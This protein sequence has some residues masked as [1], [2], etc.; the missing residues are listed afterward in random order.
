[1][2]DSRQGREQAE[3]PSDKKFRASRLRYSI[4]C[5]RDSQILGNLAILTLQALKYLLACWEC[6]AG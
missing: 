6:G 1:M 4:T 2:V 5:T 3:M